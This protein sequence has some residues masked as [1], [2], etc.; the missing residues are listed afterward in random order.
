MYTAVTAY[1]FTQGVF[2]KPKDFGSL[3]SF[4]L[5]FFSQNPTFTLFMVTVLAELALVGFAVL[6]RRVRAFFAQ[7]RQGISILRTPRRYFVGMVLP[8]ACGWVLRGAAYWYLLEAFRLGGSLRGVLL[9]MAA[10][11][12][13][14]LVPFTPGGVG[15]Q[16]ALLVVIFSSTAPG[17][18]VAVFSVGQQLVTTGLALALG[19]AALFFIFRYRS[20][21]AALRDSRSTR[22]GAVAAE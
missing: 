5:A 1:A 16:Q 17:D 6:S 4:D 12:I 18:S 19:F 11:A 20:F 21:G 13:A 10:Q 8:Q 22:R 14:S 2:P 9:V 3:Q 7:I 15:V